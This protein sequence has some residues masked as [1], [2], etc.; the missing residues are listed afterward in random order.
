MDQPGC[1]EAAGLMGIL[2]TWEGVGSLFFVSAG[3]ASVHTRKHRPA[4]TKIRLPI[5]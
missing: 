1:S 4:D 5:I 3:K 2:S